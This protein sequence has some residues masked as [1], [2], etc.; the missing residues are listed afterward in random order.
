MHGW[1]NIVDYEP[2][3]DTFSEKC[4]SC[5]GASG[6]WLDIRAIPNAEFAYQVSE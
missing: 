3:G 5:A 6:V 4:D 2:L 1:I